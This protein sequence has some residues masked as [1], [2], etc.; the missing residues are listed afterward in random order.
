MLAEFALGGAFG[1]SQKTRQPLLKTMKLGSSVEGKIV[2]LE[3]GFLWEA[4]VAPEVHHPRVV[5]VQGFRLRG[6]DSLYCP[7]LNA[8]VQSDQLHHQHAAD[9]PRTQYSKSMPTTALA[10]GPGRRR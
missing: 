10:P 7:K 9:S 2:P 1:I 3:A 8:W 4:R 5:G 6:R